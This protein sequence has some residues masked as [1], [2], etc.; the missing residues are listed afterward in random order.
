[1]AGPPEDQAGSGVY[2]G[3]SYRGQF[4]IEGLT[5]G[6]FTLRAYAPDGERE[7]FYLKSI[8]WNGKDLMQEFLEVAEGQTIEG[9]NVV[10]T[11]GAATLR[12]RAVAAADGGPA[13]GVKVWLLPAD[14]S[15]WATDSRQD[16]CVT[17][18]DG[19]CPVT[20]PPG[21]Y[22]VLLAPRG[23]PAAAYEAELMKQAVGAPRVS[24]LAHET[25]SL[26]LV[27]P[28]R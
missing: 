7:V 27:V 3:S 17:G 5:P 13:P 23:V 15:R 16:A 4:E 19:A 9:V 6:K 26:E 8:T 18:D 2:T 24:L 28:H 1:A 14:V 11:S 22:V 20:A 21:E 25:E 12:V 10:F